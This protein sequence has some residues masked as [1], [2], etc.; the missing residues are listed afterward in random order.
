MSITRIFVPFALGYFLSYLVRVVNAVIAPD[1]V[2][3]L[4]LTAADLGLLTSANFLA[5]AAAQLPLGI[6]LDRYGPRRTES[7]LLLFAALGAFLFAT[8]T[9]APGL[10]TGRALIGLGTSACL[11]AA[12]KAYVLWLPSER[13]PLV[14]GLQM[15][16]GGL[17]AVVGT[18]PVEMAMTVT[19]WRGLFFVFGG[20]A[21]MFSAIIFLVVPRRHGSETIPGTMTDQISGI[22]EVFTSPQFWR[23]APMTIASQSMFLGTQSLWSGPWMSDVAGL[24]RDTIAHH[25]LWIAI[26]MVAGFLGM[27][28]IAERLGRLGVKTIHVA[29]TGILVFAIVQLPMALQWTGAVLP[30]WMMFGFFGTAGI[31]SYAALPKFFPPEMTGRVITGLNVFTF[32]GAFAAQWG[33]GVIINLWPNAG[34]Q[35]GSGYAPEGYQAAFAVMLALQVAGLA[36]FMVFRRAKV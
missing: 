5:F 4:G 22:V 14:N 31:L 35:V 2:A 24:G 8:A 33:M 13:I 18:V 16:A 23:I 17:G 1:L 34:G 3:E 30:M 28:A 25:L 21:L 19:D 9:S 29:F 20:L 32:G 10:I 15:A 36:W 6:L 12:F 11:M 26:A 27:G 7:V